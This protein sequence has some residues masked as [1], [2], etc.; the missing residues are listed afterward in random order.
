M[1][2]RLQVVAGPDKGRAFSLGET[3]S[4]LLGR[5]K[6]AAA[7]LTDPH[8][9]RT[10]CAIE[11]RG[12]RLVLTD[13]ESHSGTYVNGERV[14]EIE[15]HPGDV[16]KVG[17]TQLRVEDDQAAGPSVRVAANRATAPPA[18]LPAERLHELKG[19]TLSHYVVGEMIGRGQSGLL[20]R[21]HDFKHERRVAFKVLW[22]QFAQDDEAVQRFIRAMK[23]AL[24]LRHPNLVS[25]YGAGRTGTYCWIAME[26][27]EGESLA[28]V[29]ARLGPGNVLDWQKALCIAVYVAR[30]LEYAHSR[31]IVHRNVTPQ[32]VLVGPRPELTKLGDLMLA[33]AR[34]GKL[35]KQITGAG[36]LLGD[37][38]YLSPEQTLGSG[39][40]DDRSDLYSLGALTYALLTGR[41]PCEGANL[42]ETITKIRQVEP[43][44][45]TTYQPAVPDQFEAVVLRML[46]KRPEKRF[47][48]T[49][50]LLQDLER[51]AR[52]QAIKV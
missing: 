26:Y 38:R 10:H 34:E 29:L 39:P 47:A 49:R 42:V 30:A 27:V 16:I 33:K 3:A 21:A 40:I 17:A 23:T 19:A 46:A 7:R 8:V 31:Q 50:L 15:L 43:I 48:E 28:Q 36:E 9:S 24:P 35:A 20:F 44:R 37:L 2:S 1:P 32:N 25:V 51:I 18:V 6:Q 52:Q 45:P 12:P 41:P 11:V 5:G 13:L 22:P 4:L 14:T